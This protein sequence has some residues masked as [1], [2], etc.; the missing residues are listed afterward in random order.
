MEIID[1]IYSL[2]R[3]FVIIALTGRTG[4][5]CTTVANILAKKDFKEFRT[6]HLDKNDG[7]ITNETR[8]DGIIYKFLSHKDNWQPFEIITASDILLFFGLYEDFDTFKDEIMGYETDENLEI[9]VGLA[10]DELKDNYKNLKDKADAA[11]EFFSREQYKI[12]PEECEKHWLF[13]KE[14]LPKFRKELKDR[15]FNVDKKLMTV[16]LQHWGDNVRRFNSILEEK[17]GPVKDAP[18]CLAK[19]INHIAKTI[20]KIHQQGENDP[21]PTRIVIDALRNPFEILYFRERFSAFYTLSVNTD[22]ETRYRKLSE[23]GIAEDLARD[24]DK[25]EKGKKGFGSSYMQINVD[26]CI[27]LSDIFLTHKGESPETNR[28][29]MNQLARYVALI[30]HP[31]LVPPTSLERVMQIAYVA[32][33]NSGCLSRQVGAAV[34]DE[35]FSVKSV[36][37]NTVAEGQTPCSL[38]NLNDLVNDEDKLAYSEFERTDKEFRGHAKLL[39]GAYLQKNLC[40]LGLPYCF[41]DYY[42]TI[43]PKQKGNQVHTRSLHAEENAFLQLGKYGSMGIKGGKLF[44]TASCCELCGKKAYQLGVKEI[45]YIDSYPGITA[46]HILQC[47]DK[48]PQMILFHGAIGSAYNSLY[49]PFVPLKDEIEERTQVHP[50]SPVDYRRS[51]ADK[52]NDGKKLA[53]TIKTDASDKLLKEFTRKV[54]SRDIKTWIIDEDQDFTTEK[55]RWRMSCWLRMETVNDELR[56]H[57][58]PSTK[59]ECTQELQG[60]FIGRIISTIYANFKAKIKALQINPEL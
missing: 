11:F 16:V 21:K 37:W 26:R 2:R 29:L 19:M 36:G 40:G 3:D 6:N 45:Y 60:I 59:E 30:L 42:T 24:I 23:K 17:D 47:G 35:N 43:K 49:D 27:E 15:I 57:I 13:I 7:Q 28:D 46:Q 14:K 8:K 1:Q 18:A 44:T 25:E 56:I 22:K 12:R 33:L 41:K 50:K 38:R 48:Q 34:T 54:R 55:D 51:I 9:A 4:S 32:K 52:K 53:L 10:L 58:I 31:G 5:G 39:H 20:R